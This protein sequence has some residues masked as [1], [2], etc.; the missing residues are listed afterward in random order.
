M[1]DPWRRFVPDLPELE[2]GL[3]QLKLLGCPGCSRIG[4]LNRHSK[5]LGNDP[6]RREGQSLR[7]QR[8]WCCPRGQR[9]GCGKTF[10]LVLAEVLP[11]HTVRA[12]LVWRW[13]LQL[14]AGASLK[15]AVE[16]LRSPFAL[17]TFYRLRRQ[18]RR[19]QDALRALLCRK[20]DPPPSAHSDPG[21]Q[22]AQHL[23]TVFSRAEC[24]PAAF[25]LQFQ[26]PFLG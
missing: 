16:T 1:L 18:L 22:T 2:K 26:L 13:L 20:L 5:L 23:Q 17:E 6:A 8:I 4:A 9:G 19:R 10:S 14:L 11:R 21:L 24:P 7:G 3:Q 15:A 25:Q 12:S